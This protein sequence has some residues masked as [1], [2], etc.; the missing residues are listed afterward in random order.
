MDANL[1]MFNLA[2]TLALW[3][4]VGLQV[5]EEKIYRLALIGEL[6][7]ARR[8]ALLFGL[9]R[10]Q[11]TP[12]WAGQARDAAKFSN[13]VY[14]DVLPG[15]GGQLEFSVGPHYSFGL[16][17]YFEQ[18]MGQISLVMSLESAPPERIGNLNYKDS[19][20]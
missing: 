18:D 2:H 16:R 13:S 17:G 6:T 15:I 4:Q 1:R 20:W 12:W 7:L 5:N 19:I 8:F 10:V 9:T 3:G 14:N 11:N